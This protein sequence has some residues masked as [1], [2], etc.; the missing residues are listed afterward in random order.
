MTAVIR[1]DRAWERVYAD[2]RLLRV[3]RGSTTGLKLAT[4]A[5]G[6]NPR[7]TNQKPPR[8]KMKNH[9]VDSGQA[10]VWSF[11]NQYL[12][13]N[14]SCAKESPI[15]IFITLCGGISCAIVAVLL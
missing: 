6:N 10:I 7:A 8:G 12:L 5:I 13:S 14:Y 15:R 3:A 11:F 2:A 1:S 4:Q 9:K